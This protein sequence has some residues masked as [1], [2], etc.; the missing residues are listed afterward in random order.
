MQM[1][2]SDGV[3]TGVMTKS[4]QYLVDVVTLVGDRIA[5]V[6]VT[7]RLIGKGAMNPLEKVQCVEWFVETTSDT[8]TF[9]NNIS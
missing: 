3:A 5:S 6:C 4:H 1:L 2:P 8:K 7:V 9:Q